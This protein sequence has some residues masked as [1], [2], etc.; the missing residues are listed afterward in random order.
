M[1][2]MRITGI[3]S[4][5][6]TETMIKDLMKAE[7]A[8]VDKV[9]KQKQY[10][11]W[12]QEGFREIT[13]KLRALQ[14]NFFDV[15][16]PSQN[17]SSSASFAKYTYSV[18]SGGI[19]SSKVT[20]SANASFGNSSIEIDSITQLASK[21]QWIGND[22]GAKGIETNDINLATIKSL[23]SDFEFTLSIGND[24]KLIK[25]TQA[26][27]V[28]VNDIN[29][30]ET[31]IKGKITAAFGSD[32]SSVVKANGQKLEFDFAG[33][34]VKMMTY[35][36]NSDSMISL[37][38][39]DASQT[40]YSY[41]TKSINELFGI[42]SNDLTGL[43]INGKDISI[44]ETDTIASM[45]DKFNKA[46]VGAT[47]RY[48]SLKDSFVME[49]KNEG[50]INNVSIQDG[51]PAE[52]FLSKLFAPSADL[53]AADGTVAGITRNVGK[54]AVLSING[55]SVVQSNNT[56]TMD[57]LTLTLKE[58]SND[59]IKVSVNQ[60]TTAI[61]DNI[62]NFVKEYNDLVDFVNGKLT[63]KKDYDY[64]PLTDE[65]KEALSDEDIEK[66]ET[67]AKA[68]MLRG[69]SEL[70][71]LLSEFRNAIIESVEASGL[72]MNQIGIG[73]SSYLDRGKLT[74]DETKLKTALENNYD[75]VVL[76][77]SNESSIKYD[78]SANRSERNKENG[79]ANRINDILKDYVRTTRDS[80]GNKG[81]LIM[82]AGI[83]NDVSQFSNEFQKKITGFDD[84]ISDLLEYLADREDYYYTMFSKMESAL[85][86]MESQSASLMSQLGSN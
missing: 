51:T 75:N 53:V 17:L 42:D 66:W 26:E 77:F 57:G 71:S 60:D 59:K 68:G 58:T 19:S 13:N 38:G 8:R 79:I 65:E 12:Q 63:E 67:K 6:D 35:A 49:S 11:T 69:S 36:S 72:T 74:V 44:D 86:Q 80:S 33:S 81:K 78:S 46:D 27:L 73:S 62:K 28:G 41:T 43:S 47:L 84:R 76:L 48:D 1:A 83:E 70:T 31:A 45:V 15:L 23:G 7:N 4:G 18:T 30:L 34:E 22:S 39:T 37:F 20:A 85:S 5:F 16:K 56:F 3:A 54:N 52:A 50:S 24:A 61:I 29:G 64:E 40:S 25:L 10:A 21:D 9:K 14:S 32:F 82:K 2:N 55:T